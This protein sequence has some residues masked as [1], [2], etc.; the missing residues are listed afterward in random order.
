MSNQNLL[1]DDFR[2]MTARADQTIELL[3]QEREE[4]A[5][6]RVESCSESG[7][8]TESSHKTEKPSPSP[9]NWGRPTALLNTRIP[10]D[11]AEALDDLV[12]RLRKERRTRVTKQHLTAEAIAELLKKYS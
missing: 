3:K 12:Y 5:L 2:V 6:E 7:V 9:A 8:R 10:A 1:A 11:M 4:E